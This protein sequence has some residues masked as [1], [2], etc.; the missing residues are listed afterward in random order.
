MSSSRLSCRSRRCRSTR[1]ATT[2]VFPL[3]LLDDFRVGL[4][5]QSA[6]AGKHLSAPVAS[7][8]ILAS[9]SRDADSTFWEPLFFMTGAY[10]RPECLFL[11]F[12]AAFSGTFY[13][14][15]PVAWD[16]RGAAED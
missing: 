3:P 6:E 14:K 7:S 8:W 15:M 1:R 16:C 5:D 12:L 13:I 2:Q 10:F 9:I 11:A 4:L